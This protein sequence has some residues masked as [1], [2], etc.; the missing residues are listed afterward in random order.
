MSNHASHP[1]VE[2]DVMVTAMMPIPHVYAFRPRSGNRLTSFLG[3]LRPGGET[4]RSPCLAYVVLH[5]TAGP[6]LIDTGLHPGA[7]EN[8]RED[9]GLR[10]ALL[11]RNVRAADVPF[12][13]QLRQLG[14]DPGEV[15]RVIMTHLHVDHTSGMR[16]LPNARFVCAREEWRAATLKGAAGKGYVAHHFPPESRMEFVDFP[17]GGEPH[18]PF[19]ATIDLLGDGSIRLVSTPGHTH[20]HM[21]VLLRVE[22]GRQV[23]VVGDAAYTLRS[24]RDE[25][26]PLL[27]V[28]DELYLSS[29]REL[30]AYMNREPDAIV[31]PSHDPA[32]WQELR[33]VRTAAQRAL[34]RTTG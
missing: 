20:G 6:V 2:V 22:G 28:S 10:M 29:L 32:A 1:T 5:P 27:T 15:E 14:A 33:A 31:I 34:A 11:F 12:E 3:I 18:G 4:M 21:S 30:K 25:I 13:E 8:L 26:L 9:F 24:I 23:L 19:S 7:S 17:S 16:L